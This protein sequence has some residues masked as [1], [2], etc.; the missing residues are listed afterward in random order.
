MTHIR[1][2]AFALVAITITIAG[3]GGGSS[4]TSSV[5]NG[6]S[7]KTSSTAT[8]DSRSSAAQA[9]S[10]GGY[11]KALSNSE[12][13]A[14]ADAVCTR[15]NVA[16]AAARHVTIHT[17][18]D[19]VNA[20]Q[21]QAA[22]ERTAVAELS[23]LTPPATLA[24]DWEQILS[25]RRLLIEEFNEIVTYAR[26]N[27]PGG[28]DSVLKAGSGVEAQMHTTAKRDGLISCASMS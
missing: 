8:V 24:H 21:K 19:V 13:I 14:K 22:I 16:A 12:L 3:C 23:K 28:V 7:S 25:I 26:E 10:D 2:A 5:A 27:N 11:G 4:N 1:L 17:M 20:A 15:F 18:Q 6:V 9:L